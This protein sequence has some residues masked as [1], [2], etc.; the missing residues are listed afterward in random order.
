[1]HIKKTTLLFFSILFL[2]FA[3]LVSANEAVINTDNL[4]VRTGPGTN[5]EKIGQV[6]TDEVYPILQQQDGWV[7]IQ[8]T[9]GTGWV[10]NEYI[11][12]SGNTDSEDT[13]EGNM[14]T[15]TEKIITIQHDNTQLRDGPST[16][17]EIT[18]FANKGIKFKVLSQNNEWYE[19][20]NDNYTG[21]VLKQLVEKEDTTSFSGMKN[22]TIVIDAGHGGRDVG[23]I[24][25]SGT[26]EKDFAFKTTQELKQELTALGAN[27]VLTRKNDEF[28]SLG[29]RISLPNILD[30]DAFISIHYNSFPEMPN[31]TGIGAYYYH[32]QNQKI[33]KD[34]LQGIAKE[35]GARN[36]GATF[37]DFHVIR[38]NFK[39]S[40]LVEL[41]FIS[42]PEKEQLLQ[43][44]AYQKKLVTGIVNGLN[45]YF[46]NQ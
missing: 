42:N 45:K 27:V 11:S 28:I 19:I 25:A 13:N 30:T 4:N 34:V 26:H 21:Y 5:F 9:Q 23:A 31:V 38:Q 33:A 24:G 36:R 7:E 32:D 18:E 14:E 6:H 15:T 16:S 35:T 3:T 41:G 20:T 8:L 43:T 39:P 29:S 2:A 46:K 1:M 10:T 12:I 40:I 44:N 22:K 37:G 17:F